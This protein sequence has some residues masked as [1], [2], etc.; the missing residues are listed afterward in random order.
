MPQT[1]INPYCKKFPGAY[2]EFSGLTTPCCWLVS[3]KKRY[4]MLKEF[5]GEGF[6]RAFITYGAEEIELVYK[7]IEESWSTD[8]PFSTCKDICSQDN[9]N[10]PL[11]RRIEE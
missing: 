7:K 1:K 9:P 10:H 8:Q 11:V 3:N 2:I 5:L 4:E 6:A